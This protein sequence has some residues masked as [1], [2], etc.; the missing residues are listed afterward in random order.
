MLSLIV[1]WQITIDVVFQFLQ[2]WLVFP[3]WF[4]L[5]GFSSLYFQSAPI[6]HIQLGWVRPTG[7]ELE[8]SRLAPSIGKS[9]QSTWQTVFLS[10][11]N[12]DFLL[13]RRNKKLLTL[14]ILGDPPKE[15]VY[16]L[17]PP[18]EYQKHRDTPS[19]KNLLLF[20]RSTRNGRRPEFIILQYYITFI[21]IYVYLLEMRKK[22]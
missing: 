22:K 16:W 18:A 6:N 20:L 2:D 1:L 5:L 13:L 9:H 7:I 19:T 21:V 4:Y 11:F 14:K 10:V 8:N 12:I 17:E 15:D 3:C